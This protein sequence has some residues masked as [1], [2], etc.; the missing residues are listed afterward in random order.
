VSVLR[1][2]FLDQV[3]LAQLDTAF[4]RENP[5]ARAFE[6]GAGVEWT[7]THL[8]NASHDHPR[9]ADLVRACAARPRLRAMMP[10]VTMDRLQF[11]RTTGQPY[12]TRGLPSARVSDE[13]ITLM[14]GQSFADAEAAADALAAAL[15]ETASA[16]DGTADDV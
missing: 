16:V 15:P 5:G 13:G 6:A 1:R 14:T 11:S 12:A 2:W 3:T 4:V 7:W 9:L 10:V 8:V